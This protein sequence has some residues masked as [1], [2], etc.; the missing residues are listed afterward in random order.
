MSELSFKDYVLISNAFVET[1]LDEGAIWDAIKKKLGGT[2][3]MSDDEIEAEIARLKK[4]DP[5]SLEKIKATKASADFHARQAEAKK[6]AMRGGTVGTQPTRSPGMKKL[7]AVPTPQLGGGKLRA[8]ERDWAMREEKLAEAL[9]F[10]VTYKLR[11]SDSTEKKT[12][13][14]ARDTTDVRRKFADTHYGAKIVLIRP[15][16]VKVVKP[17][18]V[19]EPSK[20]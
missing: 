10:E 1:Q 18:P 13:I 14:K 9:E 11:S 5:G 8:V 17:E 12:R 2:K 3:N 4:L 6:K 15:A 19:E 16:K 20:K 7:D